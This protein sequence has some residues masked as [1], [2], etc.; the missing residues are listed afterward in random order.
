MVNNVFAHVGGWLWEVERRKN[1][2]EALRQRLS[3]CRHHDW[4]ERTEQTVRTWNPVRVIEDNRQ[5]I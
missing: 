3:V 4:S 1:P 5:L 2:S